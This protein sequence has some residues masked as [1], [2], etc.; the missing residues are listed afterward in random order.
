MNLVSNLSICLHP[1]QNKKPKLIVIGGPTAIGK[2]KAAIGL[3]QRLN[4]EIISADSR[5]IYKQL[6]I[7]VGRPSDEELNSVKHHLIGN[8]DI[9]QHYHAA[10]FEQDALHILDTLYQEKEVAIVCG[11]TGL[12]IQT[13]CDGIDEMPEIRPEIREDLNQRFQEEGITFLQE[14][15]KEKDSELL[16]SIDIHNHK[17]L[18]RAAEIIIQTGLPFSSFR[19]SKKSERNFEPVFFCLYNERDIIRQNISDRVHQMFE[20]GW[21]AECEQL[22]PYRNLKALQT[23]GYKEIFDHMDGKYSLED[24]KQLIVTHTYQ[25]AKRQMT[26]FKKDN[27]YQ[28]IIH[29]DELYYNLK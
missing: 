28:W 6:S 11:G 16:L 20:N 5:Q 26:W 9:T 14:L 19:K 21:I 7:G 10:D 1:M 22:L 8:I 13:L 27:R 3:A 2:T 29:P 23:V 18:I 4:T 24:T 17:R 15:I 12:Y 25:Y